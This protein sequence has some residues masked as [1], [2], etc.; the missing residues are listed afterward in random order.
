MEHLR[1]P[2]PQDVCLA[3]SQHQQQIRR[4]TIQTPGGT[5][6]VFALRCRFRQPIYS[7]A[8]AAKPKGRIVP[9][10]DLSLLNETFSQQLTSGAVFDATA[11]DTILPPLLSPRGQPVMIDRCVWRSV[12]LSAP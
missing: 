9:H 7:G 1:T 12:T 3:S 4:L 8:M 10:I 5:M 2:H 6:I 11:T